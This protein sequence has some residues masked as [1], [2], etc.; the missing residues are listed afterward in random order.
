VIDT[1]EFKV[2][3]KKLLAEVFHRPAEQEDIASEIGI[4]PTTLHKILKGQENVHHFTM[5]KIAD[6]F[7]RK[8]E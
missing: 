5:F 7:D 8:D 4:W 1:K 6:F 3:R 2:L